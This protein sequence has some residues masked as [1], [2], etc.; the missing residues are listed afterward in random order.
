VLADGRVRFGLQLLV[1]PKSWDQREQFRTLL[2]KELS[3]LP[4]KPPYYPG[5]HQRYG[6][7][8]GH[9]RA[10]GAPH[11]VDTIH[12]PFAPPEYAEV[13]GDRLPWTL[14]SISEAETEYALRNEAFAPVLAVVELEGDFFS[15][16]G[17]FLNDNV[18]TL[19]HPAHAL[20]AYTFQP[21]TQRMHAACA[22]KR[23]ALHGVCGGAGVGDAFVHAY[24]APG[25]RQRAGPGRGGRAHHIRAQ[26][27]SAQP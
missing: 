8:V 19:R 9:Y 18:S 7:F 1:L 11:A 4:L 13:F 24:C 20:H 21:P 15:R 14:V 3:L 23:C 22:P 26:A 10:K 12:A 2:A 5:T 25:N 6:A 16:V 27:R 17:R